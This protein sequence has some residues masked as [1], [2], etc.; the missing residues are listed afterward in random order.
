MKMKIEDA[1]SEVP[2]KVEEKQ[3][4]DMEK[5]QAFVRDAIKEALPAVAAVAVQTAQGLQQAPQPTQP[6]SLPRFRGEQCP[7]CKQAVAACKSKHAKMVVFPK[8]PNYGKWFQGINL[9]GVKYLSHNGG[10]AITVPAD[11][12]FAYMIQQFESSE[13]ALQTER[14]FDHNSGMLNG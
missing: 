6:Q 12:C 4:S 1:P 11:N 9:N 7:E 5:M 10:H 13:L 8:N 3:L 2:A 14:K